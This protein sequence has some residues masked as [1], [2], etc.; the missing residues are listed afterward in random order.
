[1][2]RSFRAELE[3]N[4]GGTNGGG[5]DGGGCDDGLLCGACGATARVVPHVRTRVLLL[6]GR[7]HHA[8][9]C[10][11]RGLWCVVCG[12]VCAT[13]ED[14]SNGHADILSVNVCGRPRGRF[15]SSTFRYRL[16]RNRHAVHGRDDAKTIN[17]RRQRPRRQYSRRTVS[18]NTNEQQYRCQKSTNHG[19]SFCFQ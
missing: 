8:V 7:E 9:C 1:M 10:V 3:W 19:G 14:D 2:V 16:R 11:M 6:S 15:V 5:D 12:G 18:Q 13:S 4:L 17:A